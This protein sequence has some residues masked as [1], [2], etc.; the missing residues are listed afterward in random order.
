[1]SPLIQIRNVKIV[2]SENVVFDSLE[3]TLNKGESCLIVGAN[4]SGKSTFLKLI[5]GELYAHA[6]QGDTLITIDGITYDNPNL[7]RDRIGYVSAEQQQS[8]KRLE[9]KVSG[10]EVIE[11]G[12]DEGIFVYKPL[13]DSQK[14]AVEAIIKKFSI[15]S[16]L[17]KNF[18]DCSNGEQ[19]KLL[20]ARAITKKPAILILD[21]FENG[22]DKPSQDEFYSLL[23]SLA[24]SGVTIIFCTHHLSKLPRFIKKTFRVGDG[25]ISEINPPY[26]TQ[27]SS[28][29][30]QR[31]NPEI[32]NA[33]P[34]ITLK[35]CN[36][37]YDLKQALFDINL[38]IISGHHY[39][40]SGR[41]GSGKSTLLKLIMGEVHPVVS[42]GVHQGGVE[43]PII[44]HIP[45]ATLWDLKERIGIV[46]PHLQTDYYENITFFEVVLSG[47][48]SSIG[49]YREASEAQ[50]KAAHNIIKKFHCEHLSEKNFLHLSYGQTRK[51]LILRALVNNLEI[52]ILDEPFD[53]LDA[54]NKHE[55]E[56]ILQQVANTATIIMVTH[57]AEEIPAFITDEYQMN[58]GVLAKV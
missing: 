10:R 34:L 44:S 29:R 11:S 14:Q 41:N 49:L 27:T 40:I 53:G 16:L 30:V 7:I 28:L 58:N 18:A 20:L 33:K 37:F 13:T 21:E 46:S 19:K 54:K 26:F 12:F 15:E 35:N 17:E 6:G 48:F 55:I 56:A 3:F 24:N 42:G 25:K 1:M 57:H 38:E 4:G 52:L 47:F 45:N 23:E 36:V 43:Y 8:Y 39:L 51:A 5:K 9:I 2:R 31:G 32:K 50:I 22:L